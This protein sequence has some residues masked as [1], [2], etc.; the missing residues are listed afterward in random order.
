MSAHA[1]KRE[2]VIIHS[3][4]PIDQGYT[5]LLCDPEKPIGAYRATSHPDLLVTED[6]RM[7]SPLW[8]LNTCL[9]C[10]R[11][12]LER[13]ADTI[14]ALVRLHLAS[15]GSATCSQLWEAVRYTNEARYINLSRGI[16]QITLRLLVEAG[17][18]V[19]EERPLSGPNK[20]SAYWYRLP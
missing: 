10:D 18:L 4:A 17:N 20:V 7:F 11:V 6:G 16:L 3:I 19:Y 14:L 8:T 12:R 5:H 15:V 2:V 1:P 13:R 9:T